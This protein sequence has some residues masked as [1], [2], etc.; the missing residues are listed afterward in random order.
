MTWSVRSA[1]VIAACAALAPQPQP[2]AP[3]PSPFAAQIAALS[4]APG[5]FDTDN[6]IS[7][8]R[9]YLQV[10]PELQRR[11]I[12][13]GAYIGVGPD[14]NFSYIADLRPA[15]A[16]I[17]DI[18]RDNLLL[19]LL[20]KALFSLSRTRVEYLA[21]LTGRPVPAA[22]DGWR[23]APVERLVA[24]IDNTPAA[25]RRVDD[26]V[27]RIGVPL[28]ADDR[29]T[30][31]R[32]HGRFIAEGL[33]LRFQSTGRPPQSYNPTLRDLLRETDSAGRQAN[34]LAS[35]EGFQFVKDLQARDLVIPV[36]GDLSG[37][38]ALIAIGRLIAARGERLSAF[39]VSNVEFYLF[40][41]GTFGRFAANLERLPR[42]PNSVLIRSVF[43]RFAAPARSGDASSQ[44]LQ[45]VVE[46]LREHAA[47]RIRSYGDIAA[48]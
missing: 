3:R 23:T 35:E 42:T 30:I 22:L 19:H 44:H 6:L 47:G 11:N 33:S 16:I 36:T 43:G 28:S 38:S 9:S 20:F 14:Q 41:A 25:P 12:R 29:A 45:P 37:P 34:Y 46:L 39:Y 26:A 8:E 5:Y 1:V 21:L 40:G 48:R 4:E 18:R 13:G 32:F 31:G 17:V 27:N 15:L 24:Y 7:N 2:P 10:L